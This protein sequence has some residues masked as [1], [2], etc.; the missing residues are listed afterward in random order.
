LAA[1]LIALAWAPAAQLSVAPG[2]AVP[3]AGVL[4][5]VA[6]AAAWQL[7]RAVAA[8]ALPVSAPVP[9]QR[10]SSRPVPGRQ[11]DPAT[12]GRPRPR[13]PDR[14]APRAA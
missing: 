5:A 2:W 14:R 9:P 13:A 6:V 10:P 12:P 1:V 7:R 11:C 4:A 8:L 3:A